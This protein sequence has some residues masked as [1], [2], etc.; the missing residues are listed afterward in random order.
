MAPNFTVLVLILLKSTNGG[1]C[2]PK[3]LLEGLNF[4]FQ[5]IILHE[6]EVQLRPESLYLEISLLAL[7]DGRRSRPRGG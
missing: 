1:L 6:H 5:I 7:A 4:I 3:R 2:R